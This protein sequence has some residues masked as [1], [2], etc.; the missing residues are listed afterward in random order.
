MNNPEQYWI[1]R[2][3]DLLGNEAVEVV[4][5]YPIYQ[6]IVEIILEEKLPKV[7]EIGCNT[8]RLGLL[9]KASGYSGKYGGVDS[10]PHAIAIAQANGLDVS[11]GNLRWLDVR[12]GTQYGVVMKDVLEHLESPQLLTHALGITRQTCIISSFIPWTAE[13]TRIEQ[14][15]EGYYM[16]HYNLGEINALAVSVGWGIERVEYLQDREGRDNQIAIFRRLPK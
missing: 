14:T 16:N 12:K 8:G 3:E 6:R 15:A 5:Q 11:E 1:N 10:N 13:P 4:P 9:L 7:F 2:G